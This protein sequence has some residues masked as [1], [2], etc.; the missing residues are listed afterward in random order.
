MTR[1]VACI[2]ILLLACSAAPVAAKLDVGNA[3]CNVDSNYSIKLKPDRLV[4]THER[5]KPVVE[6]LPGGSVIVDGAPLALSAADRARVDDLERG[7]R[8]LEPEVKAIAIDAVSIAF[9]AVGHASTVFASSPREARESAE[10]IARTSR[11]L[12]KGIAAKQHWDSTSDADLDRLIEGVVGSLIGEMVGNVTAMAL[13][14]AFTGDETAIAELEARAAS[15]EKTVEEAVEKR[16][17]ALEQRA[18][19]LCTNIRALDAIESGIEAR[20]PGNARFDLVQI[21]Q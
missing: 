10:R 3:D 5:D 2:T 18:E 21:S 4:F 15:I 7:M 14:V 9:E 19:A 12:Q 1:S 13:K 17:K 8:A 11:E 20:L 6:L 16:G